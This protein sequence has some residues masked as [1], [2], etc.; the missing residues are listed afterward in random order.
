ML[1]GT[2]IMNHNL[3]CLTIMNYYYTYFM[4]IG[5]LPIFCLKV[6][7]NSIKISQLK[8]LFNIVGYGVSL[9][10]SLCLN[11]DHDIK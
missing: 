4:T 10:R 11:H 5:P 9:I 2:L 7:R 3:S 6:T 1:G 8:S